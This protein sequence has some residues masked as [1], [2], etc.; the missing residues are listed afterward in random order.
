MCPERGVRGD[1]NISV[2]LI[3]VLLLFEGT[4]SKMK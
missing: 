2:V 4:I 3:S 1:M